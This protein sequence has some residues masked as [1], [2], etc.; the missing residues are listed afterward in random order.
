MC[1]NLRNEIKNYISWFFF[2]IKCLCV[3]SVKSLN[4]MAG[5]IIE[6]RL[7]FQILLAVFLFG[8]F[9]YTK[10]INCTLILPVHFDLIV[11]M[12]FD[13]HVA[14]ILNLDGNWCIRPFRF[15]EI[16]FKV[17]GR[18]IVKSC[19]LV[20]FFLLQILKTC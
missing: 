3:L 8:E 6:G 13:F 10:S 19:K 4:W 9:S 1:D 14:R 2:Q 18:S 12:N 11:P 17:I 16:K 7:S 15:R 5:K 20:T